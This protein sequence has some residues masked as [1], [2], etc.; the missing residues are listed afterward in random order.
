VPR[1]Q[2]AQLGFDGDPDRHHLFRFDLIAQEH[3]VLK[4]QDGAGADECPPA[5]VTPDQ[6]LRLELGQDPAQFRAGGSE[7]FAQ[8]AFRWQPVVVAISS[9][10]DQVAKPMREIVRYRQIPPNSAIG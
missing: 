6:S 10:V 5:D 2:A 4:V 7:R 9:V 1:G 8:L 3:D